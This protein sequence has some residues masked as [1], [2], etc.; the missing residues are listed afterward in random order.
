MIR[1]RNDTFSIAMPNNLSKTDHVQ[2]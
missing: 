1:M 2:M